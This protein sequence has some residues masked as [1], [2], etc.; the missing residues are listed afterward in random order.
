M[1]KGTLRA[2]K[3]PVTAVNSPLSFGVK[4]LMGGMWE[5][6]NLWRSRLANLAYSSQNC[7]HFSYILAS[8]FRVRIFNWK[9]NLYLV[10]YKYIQ[11]RVKDSALPIKGYWE[12]HFWQMVCILWLGVYRLKVRISHSCRMKW[13]GA[14]VNRTCIETRGHIS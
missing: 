9:N 6:R 8:M 2:A 1:V 12:N 10:C 14:Q 13:N 7:C 4:Q 3:L 11:L 5:T